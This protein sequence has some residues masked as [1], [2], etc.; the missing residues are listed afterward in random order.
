M[1]ILSHPHIKTAAHRR[2]HEALEHYAASHQHRENIRMHLVC[3]P[4]IFTASLILLWR[5]LGGQGLSSEPGLGVWMLPGGVVTLAVLAVYARFSPRV[6]G[7]MAVWALASLALMFVMLGL[8]W[9]VTPMMLA[10]FVVAWIGQVV[11]HRIEGRKPA[12][13]D[14]LRQLLIGPLF[15][16]VELFPAMRDWLLKQNEP[17]ERS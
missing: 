12:F 7:V 17:T 8:N 4:V 13:L 10:A 1:G 3:V 11:G 14:D 5:L 16:L 6:L 15:V 9:P 2:L